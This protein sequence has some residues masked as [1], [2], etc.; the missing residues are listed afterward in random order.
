VVGEVK[1]AQIAGGKQET[2]KTYHIKSNRS[3]LFLETLMVNIPVNIQAK[4]WSIYVGR[5]AET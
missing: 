1:F 5:V 2:P 3:I 4:E